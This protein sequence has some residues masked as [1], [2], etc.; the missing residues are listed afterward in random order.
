MLDLRDTSQVTDMPPSA[1]CLLLH[2]LN[3]ADDA[4]VDGVTVLA[5]YPLLHTLELEGVLLK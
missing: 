3:L 2:T 5:S 1:L 4:Q